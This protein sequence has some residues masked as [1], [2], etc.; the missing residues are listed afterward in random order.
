[1]TK[2]KLAY[3]FNKLISTYNINLKF[4]NCGLDIHVYIISWLD[5]LKYTIKSQKYQLTKIEFNSAINLKYRRNFLFSNLFFR[6]CNF[7]SSTKKQ[8]V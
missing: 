8:N 7:C 2:L 4:P 6:S 5:F 3:L 1:M